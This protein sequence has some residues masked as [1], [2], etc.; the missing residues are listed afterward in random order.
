MLL[1]LPLRGLSSLP[2]ITAASALSSN[3]RDHAWLTGRCT[4][5]L[6]AWGLPA[7]DGQGSI[8]LPCR[9]RQGDLLAGSLQMVLHTAASYAASTIG[10]PWPWRTTRLRFGLQ[11]RLLGCVG[12]VCRTC[13]SATRSR[14]RT[15]CRRPACCLQ[16]REQQ[17]NCQATLQSCRQTSQRAVVVASIRQRGGN[18]CAWQDTTGKGCGHSHVPT[19][20]RRTAF[21]QLTGMQKT[22]IWVL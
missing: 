21:Q 5:V 11:I 13:Q 17:K 19:R 3:V 8:L 22:Q 12:K 1:L 4:W 9:C 18:C 10:M 2:L 7:A 16:Q 14:R 6:W 20:K 15:V